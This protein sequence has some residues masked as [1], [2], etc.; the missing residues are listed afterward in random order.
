[1]NPAEVVEAQMASQ[2]CRFRR[3]ALHHAAVAAHSVNVVIEQL[4]TRLVVTAGE[5]FLGDRHPDAGSDSLAERAGGGLN[6]RNPAVLGMAGRLATQL[7][8]AADILER[9]RRLTQ[10][11]VVGVYGL[12]SSEVKHGPKQHRSMTIREHKPIAVR[13]DRVLRIVLHG[14]VPQGIDER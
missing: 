7:A 6:A 12:D 11:L 8:K 5:P 3:D 1:E 13:P 14:A 9:A 10:S 2:R 4:E